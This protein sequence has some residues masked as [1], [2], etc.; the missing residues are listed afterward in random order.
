M[1]FEQMLQ[2]VMCFGE[3]S[4]KKSWSKCPK[5]TAAWCFAKNYSNNSF[6]AFRDHVIISSIMLGHFK[7]F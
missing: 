3:A 2:D 7:T 4:S 5:R 1:K 6:A